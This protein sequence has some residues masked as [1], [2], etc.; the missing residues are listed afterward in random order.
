MI[1]HLALRQDGSGWPPFD[2]EEVEAERIGVDLY[3]LVEPP[4]FAKNLAV[5][6]VVHAHEY[7]EPPLPWVES[8]V[9]P[10]GHSTIRIIVRQGA[11]AEEILPELQGLGLT[12]GPT[13]LKGLFVADLGPDVPYAPIRRRLQEFLDDGK[14]DLE[15]AAMSERHGNDVHQDESE[16]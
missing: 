9:E 2:K 8:V 15:E 3:R 13:A 1:L 6:Y 14:V 11:S 12:L 7:G 5:D 16:R 4:A 10:S